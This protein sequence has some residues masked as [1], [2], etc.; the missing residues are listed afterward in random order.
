MVESLPV[1]IGTLFGCPEK[2]NITKFR[3]CFFAL[4]RSPYHL[5]TTN[6]RVPL[7][8]DSRAAW[9]SPF[10]PARYTHEL[11]SKD[12]FQRMVRCSSQIP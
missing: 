8:S 6:K 11:S 1:T 10:R 5:E 7:G 9:T 12:L 3:M 4:I 2:E